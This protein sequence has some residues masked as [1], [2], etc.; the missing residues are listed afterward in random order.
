VITCR[1]GHTIQFVLS[2]F[3]YVVSSFFAGDVPSIKACE[4]RKQATLGMAKTV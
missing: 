4:V 2:A 1:K 3:Q